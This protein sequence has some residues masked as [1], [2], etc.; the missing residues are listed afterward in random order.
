M[1]NAA[2][3]KAAYSF[4]YYFWF[5]QRKIRYKR[6]GH[7]SLSRYWIGLIITTLLFRC[8]YVDFLC[9]FF[10]FCSYIFSFILIQFFSFLDNC[11]PTPNLRKRRERKKEIDKIFFLSHN[12][13]WKYNNR[14]NKM[15]NTNISKA[16][17]I[18]YRHLWKHL[19]LIHTV[20]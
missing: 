13:T 12:R 10:V 20:N 1:G 8:F 9:F 18:Y 16:T 17:A 11:N 2:K 5:Q 7:D 15:E 6:S 3:S 14:K 19:N 4:F